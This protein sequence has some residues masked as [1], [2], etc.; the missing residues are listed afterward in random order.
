M[1]K[2]DLKDWVGR[3]VFTSSYVWPLAFPQPL[4]FSPK[5]LK[6]LLPL[7]VSVSKEFD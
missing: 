5:S 2:L 1:V 4:G 3:G 7:C 6:L